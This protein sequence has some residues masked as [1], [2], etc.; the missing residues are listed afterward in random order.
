M[1]FTIYPLNVFN[2]CWGNMEIF[3]EGI[4]GAVSGVALFPSH[5][6]HTAL[7]ERDIQPI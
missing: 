7:Y 3:P 1:I 2:Y 5:G 6:L 4:P